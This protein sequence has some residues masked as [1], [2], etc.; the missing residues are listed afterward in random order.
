MNKAVG[1]NGLRYCTHFSSLEK[2]L[3]CMI[4]VKKMGYLNC[5][6]LICETPPYNCLV[7]A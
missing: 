1:R 3:N 4:L 7:G 6:F 2:C 5:R